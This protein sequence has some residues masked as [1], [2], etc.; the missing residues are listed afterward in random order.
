MPND[1][2]G[3]NN[4]DPGMGISDLDFFALRFTVFF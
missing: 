1:G 2:L 3:Y 4:E